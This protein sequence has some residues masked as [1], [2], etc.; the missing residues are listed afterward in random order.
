MSWMHNLSITYDNCKHK[1]RDPN[2]VFPLL[3]I[4]FTTLSSSVEVVIDSSGSFLRANS[5]PLAIIGP[6]TEESAG[7]A[8]TKIASHPLFDEFKYVA[9]DYLLFGGVLSKGFEKNGEDLFHS[10]IRIL[11]DWCRKCPDDKLCAVLKYVQKKCMIADLVKQ[12]VIELNSKGTIECSPAMAKLLK[13]IVRFSVEVHG[14]PHTHLWDDSGMWERWREYYLSTKDTKGVC[15]VTGNESLLSQQH[16]KKILPGEANAKLISSND[17]SGFTFRGRFLD[18][19]QACNVGYEVSQKAHNALTW[20]IRRQGASN[21]TQSIVAWATKQCDI[22]NPS[23]DTL[24]LIL[25]EKSKEYD[26]EISFNA[27]QNL[28]IEF[29]KMIAGYKGILGNTE[30][31]IV[32]ALD[33]MTSGRA[34]IKYYRELSGSEYLER[35]QKWHNHC[36]W[37]QRYGKDKRF[38]GA[39]SPADIVKATYGNNVDGK[40]LKA[41]IERL[42]PCIVDSAVFP[43][44]I[45]NICLNHVKRRHIFEIWE[46]EKNLGIACS[47]YKYKYT[48]RDYSMTLEEDRKSRDYLYGRLLAIAESLERV[49]LSTSNEQRPTN[50]ERLMQRFSDKPYSTWRSIELALK[51]YI[52]RLRVNRPGFLAKRENEIM[53]IKAK[54]RHDDFCDDRKLSGEFLLG[55]DCQRI[56]LP[57]W[58]NIEKTSNED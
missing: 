16:P 13:G 30:N 45:V 3:P 32:M 20:L 53:A 22:P 56:E 50:A 7:R 17:T 18:D 24:A 42:L 2:E 8:G 15:Y 39:P 55:Y 31:V 49:A 52:P 11:S 27:A 28:G 5:D 36:T 40:L 35:I 34:A 29:K 48:E 33:S 44:D 4:G 10:Y 21:D 37:R 19:S 6:C 43:L 14:E 23:M 41:T 1:S 9:G 57:P 51:P 46:W 25:R 58:K 12:K 26:S 38:V 47:L 54:F